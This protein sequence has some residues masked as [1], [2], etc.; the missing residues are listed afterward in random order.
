MSD[1]TKISDAE[2]RVC[3]IL[4]RYSP[5]TAKEIVAKLARKT[6][7]N[8]RTVK[9]L[10]NRLVNKSVLGYE[11]R[12]REYHY[13]PRL[14]EDECVK[15]ETQSFVK[16]IFDGA[17]GAMIASFLEHQQLSSREI[18]ELKAILDKKAAGK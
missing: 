3:Q 8:P 13:F 18:A 2:W 12:G 17:A 16:R 9:T 14:S 4:W 6:D 10:L 7:W 5:Q 11:S 1:A 15:A